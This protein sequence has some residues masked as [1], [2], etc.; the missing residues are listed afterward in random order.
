MYAGIVQIIRLD[1]NNKVHVLQEA[2]K[3]IYDQGVMTRSSVLLMPLDK[4]D[5][6]QSSRK[7]CRAVIKLG[8]QSSSRA[9]THTLH[10]HTAQC[11]S[12]AI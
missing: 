6:A 7:P 1:N 8:V 11:F 2:F 4:P 9:S 5:K 10:T 12:S 3:C